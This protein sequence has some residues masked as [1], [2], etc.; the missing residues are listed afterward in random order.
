[1]VTIILGGAGF[2]GTYVVKNLA[3]RGEDIIVYDLYAPNY[4]EGSQFSKEVTNRIVFER[5]DVLDLFNLLRVIKRHKPD[6]IIHLA[7]ML[8]E[9]EL[10]PAKAFKVNC[11]SVINILEI[12]RTVES[13]KR[14]VFASSGHV[15]G[16]GIYDPVDEEHPKNPND[17][18]G[19][20]KLLGEL[21]GLKYHE[22]FGIDFVVTRLAPTYGPGRK[23]STPI[24]D[25]VKNAI[26]EKKTKMP[27]GGDHRIEYAFV[28]D[29]AEGLVL[30]CL[31]NEIEHRVFN[32]GTGKAYSLFE[33]AELVK[34]IIPKADIEL[35]QGII[36]GA[37]VRGPFKIDRAISELQ[38]SPRYDLKK[39][40]Q[41]CI[42]WYKKLTSFH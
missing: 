37:D 17:F 13:I 31:S 28:E 4:T 38:Y 30:A 19:I 27:Y 8:Q 16:H 7:A 15:Y 6:R 20:T 25:F 3:C 21:Y 41:E 32:I 36:P 11:E 35:G 39:G 42:K 14:I 34:S 33:V 9:A 40:V 1:M 24:M 10:N 12:A 2:I 5:G 29:I 18:Y 23:R 26:E 22:R